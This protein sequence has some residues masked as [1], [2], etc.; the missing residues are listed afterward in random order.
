MIHDAAMAWQPPVV[1][2]CTSNGRLVSEHMAMFVVKSIHI[3]INDHFVD[4]LNEVDYTYIYIFKYTEYAEMSF[5]SMDV[6][7]EKRSN[8]TKLYGFQ[9][10]DDESHD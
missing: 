2:A 10:T 4:L 5:R 9:L 1:H 7:L 6:N 8:G 3:Q